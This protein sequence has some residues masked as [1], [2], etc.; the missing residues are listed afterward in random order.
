MSYCF[1]LS[2]CL[3]DTYTKKM[4][5]L[6]TLTKNSLKF[7]YASLTEQETFYRFGIQG[8]QVLQ[9][10]TRFTR[11]YKILQALQSFIRF[12]SFTLLSYFYK[13]WVQIHTLSYDNLSRDWSRATAYF[14]RPGIIVIR[15]R[16]KS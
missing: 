10:F 8:L 13:L 1:K 5:C 2:K 7:T 15:N 4:N 16:G 12:T 3:K 11:N 6:K 14:S 9:G